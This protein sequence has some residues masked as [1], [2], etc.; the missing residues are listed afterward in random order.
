MF[1]EMTSHNII[2]DDVSY[3]TLIEALIADGYVDESYELYTHV[4]NGTENKI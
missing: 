1:D 4:I 3:S 2:P